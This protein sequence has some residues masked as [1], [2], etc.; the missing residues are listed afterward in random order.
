[1]T[2]DES[3]DYPTPIA[4][5]LNRIGCYTRW[6]W[7]R[8]AEMEAEKLPDDF[9]P[10]LLAGYD[11]SDLEACEAFFEDREV[12]GSAEEA[13]DHS[14]DE[15]EIKMARL[16]KYRQCGWTRASHNVAQEIRDYASRNDIDT[17]RLVDKEIGP[18][19]NL[20]DREYREVEEAL[21]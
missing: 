4:V 12:S 10:E 15:L 16:A 21:L 5:H 13:L 1:M 20:S 14:P 18:C 11:I 6:G 7:N 2:D 8:S 17:A 3:T 19:A 9:D